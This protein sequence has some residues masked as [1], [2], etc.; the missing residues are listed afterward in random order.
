M[1]QREVSINYLICLQLIS[2]NGDVCLTHATCDM[3][4]PY[5]EKPVLCIDLVHLT[6]VRKWFELQQQLEG[7]IVVDCFS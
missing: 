2:Q 7:E 4:M 3:R 6:C 1:R 5:G